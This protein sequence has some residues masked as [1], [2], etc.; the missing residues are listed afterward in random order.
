MRPNLPPGPRGKLSCTRRLMRAPFAT[1]REWQATYGHTF[2]VELLNGTTVITADPE[3]VREMFSVRDPELF[4]SVMPQTFDVLLGPGSILMMSGSTHQRER[5]LLTPPFHGERLRGWA[6]TMAAAGREVFAGALGREVRA[7]DRTQRATLEVIVRVV[8]GVDE[9]ARLDEFVRAV[10][11]WTAAIKPSFLFLRPLQRE[12]FGLSPFARYRRASRRLDALLLDQIARVEASPEGREDVL[13]SMVTARYED[14][15]RMSREQIRDELRTLLI[16]G[17]ETTAVTLAWALYFVHRDP[18]VR[19]RL[20]ADIAALGSDEPDALTRVPYL[21]A[22]I[23]ETLRLRPVAGQNFRRLRKP[24]QLG[25]WAI[26]AGATVSAAVSLIHHRA[27]LWPEPERF[28]PERFID[29]ERPAGS[30]R[31][32]PFVYLPF[33]GGA[34]RCLGATFARYEA[35]VILG[36]LLRELKFELLDDVVAWGRG[37]MTLE[38]LGG[39]RVRVVGPR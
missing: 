36:T 37:R 11:E 34:H 35:S 39:V 17:H 23:D 13:A 30:E 22:V 1:L 21:E 15:G 10:G 32:G 18:A 26:P 33:G 2:S 4:S 3:L 31:P 14:G 38:P 25:E 6:R 27:D 5:R 8:F 20:L 7:L 29:A 9:A 24:W 28:W 19:E 16:A 12:L